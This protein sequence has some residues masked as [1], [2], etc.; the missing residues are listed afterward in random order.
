LVLEFTRRIKRID[1]HLDGARADD[2]QQGKREG[3]DIGKH[4]GDS[5]RLLHAQPRLQISRELAR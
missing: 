4:Y 3:R 2:P 5:I 1:I